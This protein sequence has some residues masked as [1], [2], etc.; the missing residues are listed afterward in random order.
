MR[1][2]KLLVLSL[3]LTTLSLSA[4][5][6][7][8][9]QAAE[10]YAKRGQDAS[11]AQ[12]AADM[13]KTLASTSSDK[14]EKADLLSN[15]AKALFYVGTH[16]SNNGEKKSKH[17]DG[18]GAAIEAKDLLNYNPSEEKEK[19]ALAT[20][21]YW[22]GANLGKW[23][24]ANGVASSLGRWPTLKNT[25][26]K[27]R[28][29]GQEKL[30]HYGANRILGRAYYKLPFPLGS[31]K[32]AY[33]YL[34]EAVKET[35]EGNKVSVLGLN[36]LYLADLLVAIGKRSSAKELLQAFVEADAATLN[37]ER[38]PETLEEQEEARK[39]LERL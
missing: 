23:A 2:M 28:N 18:M 34:S 10:L 35:K 8:V 5:A 19:L 31:K 25:M 24:E 29:L 15:A 20:A 6:Q 27:I 7:S 26:F 12:Q 4:F 22:Y 9:E 14:F 33:S 39:K 3:V 1:A 30:E 11:F 17:N 36:N 21:L 37:P 32:K 38:V 13:Y 16:T